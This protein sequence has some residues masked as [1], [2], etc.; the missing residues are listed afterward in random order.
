MD[1]LFPDLFAMNVRRFFLVS[2]CVVWW[3]AP[4]GMAQEQR[5]STE[6]GQPVRPRLLAP[7]P[8]AGPTRTSPR[9][10]W[11]AV[12]DAPGYLLQISTDSSFASCLVSDTLGTDTTVQLHRAFAPLQAF[13]WRIGVADAAGGY[14]FSDTSWCV[15]GTVPRARQ[16]TIADSRRDEP[17]TAVTVLRNDNA[18]PVTIDSALV[19][20]RMSVLM[21][22][23]LVIGAGDSL[24][25]HLN[26][27]PRAFGE[28]SDTLWMRGEEGVTGVPFRARCSP[29]VLA[30]RFS[31]ITLGPCAVSDS[32]AATL[33]FTNAGPFNKLTVRRVRTRT[34]FFSASFLPVRRL[35]P[36]EVLR[37]PVKF[38]VRAF[39]AD[40]FGTYTDTCLVESD[41]GEGRVV[42]RGESPSPRAWVEPQVLSFGDVASGDT[43]I[44]VL[45]LLNRSVNDLRI[46]SI[47]TRTR[48]VRPLV[49]RGR[50]G[51]TDTL[52][53]PF[54]FVAGKYGTF[55][56]TVSVA[57]N[58]WWGALR[59]PV[60][61]R[62]PLPVLETGAD[63]V[64]FG[65][66][67]K[68]D[69]AGV[70]IRIANSSI[71]P[72]RVD[73]IRTRTKAFRFN[74][75]PLPA[76]VRKGDTLSFTLY[77]FP[78]SVRFFSDTLVIGSSA[79][80]SPRKIILTGNGSPPGGNGG[81][82]ATAGQFELYQNFPNP[83]RGTTTFR[84][85]LPEPGHVRL[86]IFTTL[87]QEVAV[88][89]DGEQDAGFHNV[90]WTATVTSGVYYFRLVATPRSDQSRQYKG[91]RKMVVMR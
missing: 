47:G 64:D 35:E 81:A 1:S 23:P 12:P 49:S 25:V 62:I 69:T 38:H 63:R 75:P 74:R 78:D 27:R 7:L 4:G 52:L 31:Q 28:E 40:A 45:R 79:V 91:T 6:G 5:P 77:F 73:S 54:R 21:R 89:V 55:M 84:Y 11:S 19:H 26:Y 70:V 18:Y 8:G 3:W 57:N 61:A 22:M 37:V 34:Q 68:S 86:E 50:I 13:A 15:T 71:S 9:F 48:S 24:V 83:F 20:P 14:R 41:G 30:A 17:N 87:G 53:V 16:V 80:G 56:D 39:K 33:E 88:L 29:P 66:V 82:T 43:A 32:A 76:T 65:T 60:I 2:C 59:V 44:A 67:K 85:V 72:L 36:G 42:L 58:S 51:R 46:D 90:T 10:A